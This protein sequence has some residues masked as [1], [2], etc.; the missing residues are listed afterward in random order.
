MMR[1]QRFQ[2][3][4][5]ERLLRRVRHIELCARHVQMLSRSVD[6]SLNTPGLDNCSHG[7]TKSFKTKEMLINLE[8]EVG[9]GHEQL[10]M[11]EII[12]FSVAIRTKKGRTDVCRL[13]NSQF[14][15]F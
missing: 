3:V 11:A 15:E 1:P 10:V 7:L 13:A 12:S 14:S 6:S 2:S 8:H 9:F 5:W 4:P